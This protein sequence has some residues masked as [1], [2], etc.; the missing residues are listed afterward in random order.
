MVE[1][2]VVLATLHLMNFPIVWINWIRAYIS[3]AS[4]ALLITGHVTS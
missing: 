2:E 1:W 4:F 3:S